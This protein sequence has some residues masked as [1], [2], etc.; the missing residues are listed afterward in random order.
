MKYAL[1]FGLILAACLLLL[2][3]LPAKQGS[4]DEETART[5]VQRLMRDAD[6]LWREWQ[7]DSAIVFADRAVEQARHWLGETDTTYVSALTLLGLYEQS[8]G[9][10]VKS[11]SLLTKAVALSECIF[12]AE[13]PKVAK[14]LIHLAS[15]YHREGRF[16][17]A[18]R[19]HRRALD[20]Q[21]KTLGSESPEVAGTWYRLSNLL[22][23]QKRFDEADSALI[24][25]LHIYE[26]ALGP[27]HTSVAWVFYRLGVHYRIRSRFIEAEKSLLHSLAILDTSPGPEEGQVTRVLNQLGKLY[28]SQARYEEA[29]SYLRRGQEILNGLE[30]RTVVEI[31]SELMNS[32]GNLYRAQGKLAEAEEAYEQALQIREQRLELRGGHDPHIAEPL[33]NLGELYLQL[34]RCAEAERC[35]QRA[36]KA[37]VEWFGPDHDILVYSLNGLGRVY[38]EQG[39]YSEADSMFRWA[40]TNVEEAYGGKHLHVAW[41]LDALGDINRI[42]GEY[43]E[44]ESLY[45]AALEIREGCLGRHHPGIAASLKNLAM[46]YGSADD[47]GR[48]VANYERMQQ[49][50]YDF[51]QNVF[52]YASEAQKMR[53]VSSY[54]LIDHSFLSLTVL[55][56]SSDALGSALKMVLQ[57]KAIVIDAVMAEKE[58]ACCSFDDEVVKTH[59]EHER[60]CNLIANIALADV[61]NFPKQTYRDSLQILHDVKDSLETELSRRCSEFRDELSA[62]R[63]SLSEIADIL[64]TEAVLWEFVRYEPYDFV[65]VGG[66]KKKTGPARYLAFALTHSAEVILVDLGDASEIDSLVGLARKMIYDSGTKV[67]SPMVVELEQQLREVTG[68]LY[69]MIFAPLEPTL[70]GRT[71]I[72]I[73]PDGQLS[74]LPFEILPHHDGKYVIDSF[75]I[76]YLSSGR[77]LLRFDRKRDISDQALVIADPDFDLSQTALSERAEKTVKQSDV[78]SFDWAPARGVSGCLDTRFNLLRYSRR[79]SEAVAMML[80]KK[81]NLN[82]NAYY[83]GDALEE[84]LKGITS[85]PRV[86]HLATHGYFCEDIDVSENRLLENPLLR[87]G[88]ALAGA[89]RLIGQTETDGPPTEDGILTAFEVSR[90][91]LVGT[92]LIVLSA[93]ETGI[94]DI[95]NGEGVFGLRRAFQHAGARA[96]LM[97]LWK[98]PDKETYELMDHFYSIWLCGQSK[99]TALRQSVLKVIRSLREE[100]GVAHPYFWGGF[101]LVG[102]PNCR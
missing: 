40:L 47:F 82:V 59:E 37:R 15:L 8:Q 92:E 52:S 26:K 7:L 99:R 27:Q 89:N 1:S 96:V 62:R 71:E 32:L 94:G 31:S 86:L 79:E 54:P 34:G 66:D 74:L 77:D 3:S 42:Q 85:A 60:M 48:S 23:Q 13:H 28:V 98:V 29:E 25:A 80:S 72:L 51:I 81:G 35:F 56:S 63:F 11:E 2:V 57:G 100:Y 43:L 46:L 65:K 12:G 19:L 49:L 36:L 83:G 6:S 102:D 53:Y 75:N 73:S 20:I 55:D 76:S 67:Y 22:Y 50:R 4:A 97:S 68:K 61:T 88:L 39:K 9:D 64:P 38:M 78:F 45:A 87:S 84:V 70:A 41:C 33:N 21:A 5:T 91:N 101:V 18:E 93:C 16:A 10:F 17:E 95:K 14:A 24:H 30:Q 69:D 44:A 58:A 90:L